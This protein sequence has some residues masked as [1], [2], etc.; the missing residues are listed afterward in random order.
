MADV[1]HTD[2]WVT[3]TVYNF[4]AAPATSIP[5]Q[6]KDLPGC[7]IA[8]KS[9]SHLDS[10]RD[11]VPKHADVRFDIPVDKTGTLEFIVD[12]QNTIE[13]IFEENNRMTVKF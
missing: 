13:E 7:S 5:V 2:G 4:G 3:A 6:L 1:K 11:F 12:P 8:E 9:I 10:A